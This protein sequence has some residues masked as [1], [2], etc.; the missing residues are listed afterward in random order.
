[1]GFKRL[2]GIGDPDEAVE[3]DTQILGPVY[4]G[5]EVKGEVLLRGGTRDTRIEG[6]YLRFTVRHTDYSGEQRDYEFDSCVAKPSD[7]TLRKGEEERLTF[8]ERLSWETP[9]S[10][11]GG[12]ALGVVLSV[13]SKLRRTWD[14][15]G[16]EVD[17]DLLHISALPL[18]EAVLDAFAEEGYHCDSAYVV[19]ESIPN[20]EHHHY[21]HQCFVLTD[22]ASVPGRPEQ[23]EVVFQT[24]VVGAV[25]HVRR[26]TP[27]VRDWTDKPPTRRFPAAHHEIGQV[28][29]RPRVRKALE[30][31]ALLDDQ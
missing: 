2:F 30:E 5:G 17:N 23:L 21:F 14:D 25:V 13:K 19:D 31:L 6:I 27:D 9:V 15:E 7:I 28:D 18:H 29:W 12:R 16:T 8:S 20:T 26:A 22:H 24:N 3:V 4:P 10:E 11:L 1:M